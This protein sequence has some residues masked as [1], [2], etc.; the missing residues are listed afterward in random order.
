MFHADPGFRPSAIE[1]SAS[2]A[3]DGVELEFPIG[4]SGVREFDLDLG[5]WDDALVEVWAVEWDVDPK[6]LVMLFR[7]RVGGFRRSA[8]LA[9]SVVFEVRSEVGQTLRSR[10]PACSP[11]CRAELG[12]D[13]CGVDL[14]DRQSEAEARATTDGV[15]RLGAPPPDPERWALGWLRFLDGP[16]AGVDRRIL[17]VAG[18]AVHVEGWLPSRDEV[19]WRVGL[20]EGCDKRLE[21]CRSRFANALSFRGEPFVPG[22]DALLRF[23]HE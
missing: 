21:T 8:A 13:R 22:T 10:V 20:T 3:V 16:L 12:D 14:S 17:T 18:A 5:R 19:S 4:R 15:V 7:G 11:L 1:T 9:A 2:L 23:G 6:T